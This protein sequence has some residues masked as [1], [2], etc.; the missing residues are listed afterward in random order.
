MMDYR[1]C[2][3]LGTFVYVRLHNTLSISLTSE[4]EANEKRTEV[5]A[6]NEGNAHTIAAGSNL[7]LSLLN[8]IESVAYLT[9]SRSQH[10]TES[11]GADTSPILWPL[12]LPPGVLRS[13]EWVGV[14]GI[15]RKLGLHLLHQAATTHTAHA[16]LAAYAQLHCEAPFTFA[17]M[18]CLNITHVVGY[19]Q[20]H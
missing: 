16:T 5:Q 20:F 19:T 13:L 9:K 12:Q 14:A 15:D 8:Q 2:C 10:E 18:H 4:R 11:A 1:P 17:Q 6:R 7:C 3:D